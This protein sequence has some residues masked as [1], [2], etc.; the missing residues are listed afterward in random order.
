MR[1][2][3][4]GGALLLFLSSLCCLLRGARSDPS[5]LRPGLRWR[6]HGRVY[7]LF[8]PGAQYVPAG[9][10]RDGGSRGP[11][12]VISDRNETAVERSGAQQVDSPRTDEGAQAPGEGQSEPRPAPGPGDQ[13]SNSP[14]SR[15]TG[16]D[17]MA[18]DDPYDPYKSYRN[19][20]YYNPYNGY[21]GYDSYYTPRYRTRQRPNGYSTRTVQH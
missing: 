1:L 4:A 6:N 10:R 18:A 11:V 14:S 2:L 5:A 13:T 20:L 16:G 12:V 19:S 15:A 3:L 21:N 9:R 8:S 7:N 17:A